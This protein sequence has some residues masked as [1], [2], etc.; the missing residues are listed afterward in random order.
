MNRNS[1]VVA[2]RCIRAVLPQST[3]KSRG[4]EP[5]VRA[6]LASFGV[7]RL[8]AALG[9]A[10]LL[11]AI[12]AWAVIPA[13]KLACEKAAASCRTPK[14]YSS[15]AAASVGRTYFEGPRHLGAVGESYA[16]NGNLH[17]CSLANGRD[18]CTG[19]CGEWCGRNRGQSSVFSFNPA[20]PGS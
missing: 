14:C 6:T 7:R 2:S 17:V 15:R 12:S 16:V 10:S 20:V 19:Q 5:H 3:T 4:P 1:A 13:S 9:P 11:S 18:P 8:A